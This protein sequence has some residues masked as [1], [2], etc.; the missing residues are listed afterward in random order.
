MDSCPLATV[1]EGRV[2]ESPYS[3]NKGNI[4]DVEVTSLEEAKLVIAALRARQKEQASAQAYQT[5]TWRRTL[6]VQ[7]S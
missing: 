4:K 6:K 1:T 2:S 3:F 7:V 5:F